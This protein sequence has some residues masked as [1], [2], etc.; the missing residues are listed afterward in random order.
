M[1]PIS[2][3]IP[4]FREQAV[5][6]ETIEAVRRLMGGDAAEII[7]VDGGAERETL[8]AMR[9]TAAKR[10][11][12]EKGRGAQLNRGA[13]VAAGDILLF[14]HADTILPPS[15]FERIVE[16][17]ADEDCVGGAFDLSI[18]SPGAGFRVIETVAN[19]RSRLTRIPYGDQA[20]FIRASLFRSLG[21]FAEIP[22][23]EDVEFMRRIK[24]QGGRIIIFRE[25]VLTSGRRW[26]EEGLLFGTLRNWSLV[27]L[28]LC[29]VPP[30]RLARFYR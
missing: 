28:Y 29:G 24:R 7:V 16:A 6:N 22:I 15:A 5:I 26:E 1:A 3:I 2:V 25:P 19:L 17:M 11:F 4:V 20:I 10:V 18:D 14:L 23:M 12:S 8:A 27:T 21:G 13:A 9:D 30:E